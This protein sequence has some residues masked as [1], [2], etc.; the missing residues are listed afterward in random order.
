MPVKLLVA[1]FAM[2]FDTA[3]VTLLAVPDRTA[4]PEDTEY[5]APVF[6]TLIFAFNAFE[7]ASA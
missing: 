5:D 4:Y 1:R 7:I 3:A 6:T 2:A